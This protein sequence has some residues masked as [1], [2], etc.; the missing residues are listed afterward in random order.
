M[1][2]L[3]QTVPSDGTR[4]LYL[5]GGQYLAIIGVDTLTAQRVFHCR[6]TNAFG[7]LSVDSPTRYRFNITGE[8]PL[9]PSTQGEV[10]P[11]SPPP[12][13]PRTGLT[14]YKPLQDVTA[15][16]GDTNIQFSMVAAGD[17]S[18]DLSFH[19]TSVPVGS[20]LKATRLTVLSSIVGLVG[21]PVSLVDSG[22]VVTCRVSGSL[23]TATLTVLGG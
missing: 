1:D 21:G 19:L 9:F 5:E 18:I 22:A 3:N 14:I 15:Y 10:P 20:S 23:Y 8:S 17:G 16:E 11:S 6:V 7:V 4:F 12:A 2:G 13:S